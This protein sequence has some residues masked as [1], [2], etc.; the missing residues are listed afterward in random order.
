MLKISS[1]TADFTFDNVAIA[2]WSCVE[3]NA[4]VCV[5]CIMT[6][7]P[8]L[9]K[10]FPNLVERQGQGNLSLEIA[11]SGRVLTIGSRPMR[12]PPVDLERSIVSVRETNHEIV[13]IKA[14]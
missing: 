8:L 3:T 1:P 6:F 12:R 5:A 2:F 10:W 14:D 13:D 11:R 9:T 4:T 7:K